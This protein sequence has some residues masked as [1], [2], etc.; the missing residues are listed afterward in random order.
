MLPQSICEE[1][2]HSEFAEFFVK[3]ENSVHHREKTTTKLHVQLGFSSEEP[4]I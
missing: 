1:D 4:Q 3:D 2:I